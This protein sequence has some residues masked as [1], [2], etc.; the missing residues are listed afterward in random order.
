MYRFTVG[1]LPAGFG[2]IDP[3][4]PAKKPVPKKGHTHGANIPMITELGEFLFGMVKQFTYSDKVSK[5]T[6]NIP[7]GTFQICFNNIPMC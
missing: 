5:C 4:T 6:K 7:L 2:P 3:A 1:F